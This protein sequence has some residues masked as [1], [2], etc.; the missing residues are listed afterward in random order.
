MRK[1]QRLGSSIDCLE[2]SFSATADIACPSR[3]NI[4]TETEPPPDV[5]HTGC[6]CNRT[7]I[8]LAVDQP[9]TVCAIPPLFAAA[10][11]VFWTPLNVTSGCMIHTTVVNRSSFAPSVSTVTVQDRVF[12]TE[13][14]TVVRAYIAA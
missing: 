12:D 5:C 7:A 3:A 8:D 2:K 6:R 10:V 4:S 1:G 14:H 11:T 13:M 9:S